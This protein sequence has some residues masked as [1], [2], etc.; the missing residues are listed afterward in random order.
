MAKK[1][2][3]S[4]EIS[5]IR[6]KYDKNDGSLRITSKDPDLK[7]KPFTLTVTGNSPSADTIFKL[8]REHGL[9]EDDGFP[10][11]LSLESQA[12]LEN[13][14]DPE[15]ELKFA[16]GQTYG[17]NPVEIDLSAS[18]H[19][20]VS[21][22]PGSGKSVILQSIAK[23]IG[24]RDNFRLTVFDPTGVEWS[25][26]D[27]RR[28]DRILQSNEALA[29]ELEQLEDELQYRYSRMDVEGVNHSTLMKTPEPYKILLL[30]YATKFLDGDGVDKT[31]EV[32][33]AKHE[34]AKKRLFKLLRLGRAAGI[35]VIIGTQRFDF[36]MMPGESLANISTRISMGSNRYTDTFALLG[37]KPFYG[38]GLLNHKGRGVVSVY[39]KQTPFQAY[40][41][42]TRETNR[43]R[44]LK[45][46]RTV[47]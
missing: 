28:Q 41:V 4:L 16:L 20:L 11:K 1:K 22:A 44:M 3:S 38:Q 10:A 42:D 29:T 13:L 23:Q 26:K 24:L 17:S 46:L 6:V 7:G 31:D 2:A 8:M 40:R 45:M 18:P 15:E 32:A 43:D 19:M 47:N 14:Y 12:E 27:L 5:D 36:G 39:G 37:D 35:H 25:Q 30:D 21:G 9:V 33:V 34:L